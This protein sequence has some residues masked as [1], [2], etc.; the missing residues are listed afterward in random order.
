M[1]C[2]RL[3]ALSTVEELSGLNLGKETWNCV[4]EKK[5]HSLHER[6]LAERE[7]EERPSKRET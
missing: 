3:E 1:Q 4:I 5:S 6:K 7:S 2:S